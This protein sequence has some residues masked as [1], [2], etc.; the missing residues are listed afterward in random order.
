MPARRGV[1][2]AIGAATLFGL[3]TP[4]VKPL[5]GTVSPILLAGLLYG[6]SALGLIALLIARRLSGTLVKESPIGKADLPWLAGSSLTG[7]LLAPILLFAG[8]ASLPASEA[9]LLLNLE[10][11]FTV[12]IAVFIVKEP[13]GRQVAIGLALIV[14]GGVVLSRGGRPGSG[15]GAAALLVAAACLSWAVDT[16]LM[17]RI[18]ASDPMAIAAAKSAVGGA[19]NVALA[20][21]QGATLPSPRAIGWVLCVGFVGYG[22][23]LTLFVAALRSLGAARTGA[24]FAT[25]PFAG[26][27]A[28]VLW[29]H[30]PMGT[31]ILAAAILMAVGVFLL[32]REHQDLPPEH[33]A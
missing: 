9:S 4:A 16:N 32:A 10:V 21:A 19:F 5:A 6:G 12:A 15:D 17:R 8:L 27:I 29:F 20:L 13:V 7:G 31:P 2:E 23:S 3:S 18:A 24:F 30:E 14:A 22:L 33:P 11:A 25:A 1:V 26:A 28:S